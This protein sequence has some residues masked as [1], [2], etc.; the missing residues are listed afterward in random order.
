[1]REIG[2]VDVVLIRMLPKPTVAGVGESVPCAPVPLRAIVACEL[3]ALLL[4]EILP[5]GLPVV[6]GANFAV[7]VMFLPAAITW[8]A[9]NPL[10]L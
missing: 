9:A 7:K 6:V 10:A 1:M 8:P 2:K 4:I 3:E 5:A